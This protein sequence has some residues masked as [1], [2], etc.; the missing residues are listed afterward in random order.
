MLIEVLVS[1][2]DII[3]YGQNNDTEQHLHL[4]MCWG[5]VYE[6]TGDG[7]VLVRMAL[8]LSPVAESEEA[9]IQERQDLIAEVRDTPQYQVLNSCVARMGLTQVLSIRC[10][11]LQRKRDSPDEVTCCPVDSS[12]SRVGKITYCTV[13]F[14]Q[15]YSYPACAVHYL[16]RGFM[17][18][19]SY[20]D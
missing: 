17:L 15:K 7:G 16:Q 20:A 12:G 19:N 3:S 4:G 5:R 10:K 11:G 2:R 1:V 9:M 13:A 8:L 14:F 6:I 18:L